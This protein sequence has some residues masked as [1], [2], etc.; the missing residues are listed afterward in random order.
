MRR[1]ISY[2]RSYAIAAAL[3]LVGVCK[4]AG[5]TI[6]TYTDQTAW[7]AAASG[8][9]NIDFNSLTGPNSTAY[10]RDSNGLTVNSVLFVGY[11]NASNGFDLEV[12]NPDLSGHPFQS[13]WGTG[14]F[15]EGPAYF[16][17]SSRIQVTLPAGIYSVGSDVMTLAGGTTPIAASFNVVLSTGSTVYSGTTIGNFSSLAF[18]GFTSDV[19]ISSIAFY[20]STANN[21]IVD[22]FE[23]GG[24]ASS[25][26]PEAATLLLSGTGLLFM[27][28]QWRRSATC[29]SRG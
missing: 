5:A 29:L 8:V 14:S 27:V 19:P 11:D 23:F 2:F 10:Y 18:I 24:Q 25:P 7:L 9:S 15:L 21:I 4:P 26:T 28:Y 20:P 17:S 16:N 1:V 13:D 12:V 22:N 3:L 6:A